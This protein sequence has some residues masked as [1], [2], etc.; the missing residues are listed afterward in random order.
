[1]LCLNMCMPSVC[2]L[3]KCMLYAQCCMYPIFSLMSCL[4]LCS[5]FPSPY[6]VPTVSPTPNPPSPTQ[7]LD[8]LRDL[9]GL[10]RV[11]KGRT[12]ILIDINGN[13]EAEAVL[14]AI[15]NLQAVVHQL[16]REERE[17][18]FVHDERES[19][20]GSS[21][22]PPEGRALLEKGARAAAQQVQPRQLE[23]EGVD[24]VVRGGGGC[25]QEL[26]Q[27][28]GASIHQQKLEEGADQVVR[29]GRACCEEG[30][31]GAD[32]G[33]PVLP[34]VIVKSRAV[35]QL[36]QRNCSLVEAGAY[37]SPPPV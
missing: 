31:V 12:V 7:E 13:R 28:A 6:L 35:F 22:S 5:M 27:G 8:C 2:C 34:L 20:R 14:S 11:V 19:T 16:L 32:L 18:E 25:Q 30:V 21:A 10:R 15:A 23:E 4:L 17:H 9:T 26:E 36:L 37:A 24:A 3:D 29:G 33:A 1:M